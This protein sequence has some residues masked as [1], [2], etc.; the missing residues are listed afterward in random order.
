MAALRPRQRLHFGWLRCCTPTAARRTYRPHRSPSRPSPTAPLT[1][2]PARATIRA[3]LP[4]HSTGRCQRQQRADHGPRRQGAQ[5]G[6]GRQSTETREREHPIFHLR[7]ILIPR[8]LFSYPAPPVANP[9]PSTPPPVHIRIRIRD[10]HLRQAPPS[11]KRLSNKQLKRLRK[12]IEQ[13][14]K[15]ALRSQLL[16]DIAANSIPKQQQDLLH[17]SASIASKMTVK[18]RLRQEL[19][20]ERAGISVTAD[21]AG[22]SAVRLTVPRKVGPKAEPVDAFDDDASTEGE[23]DSDAEMAATDVGDAEPA[24]VKAVLLPRNHGVRR[25]WRCWCR[26]LGAGWCWCWVL[27]RGA[28]GVWGPPIAAFPGP[29]YCRPTCS[30]RR[31]CCTLLRIA[32]RLQIAN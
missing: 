30:R 23:G 3:T 9:P 22:P 5:G 2:L 18:Q 21:A 12:V 11:K 10:P 13:K 17:R 1:K 4:S 28:F 31:V 14:E 8:A 7:H 19:K 32:R 15:R 29:L 24:P 20:E 27:V 6:Q 25:A 16:E 26:V